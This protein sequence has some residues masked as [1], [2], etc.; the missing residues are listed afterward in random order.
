M[1]DLTKTALER[2]E[3]NSVKTIRMNYWIAGICGAIL[4]L[5]LA[6]GV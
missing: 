2:I 3:M 4:G 5:L 6:S 1:N